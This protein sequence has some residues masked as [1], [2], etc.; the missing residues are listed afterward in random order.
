[1]CPSSVQAEHHSRMAM[2]SSHCLSAE[3]PL[4]LV[5]GNFDFNNKSPADIPWIELFE[6]RIEM[7]ISLAWT[8]KLT[9]RQSM[10]QC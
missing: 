7:A 10:V 3:K 8:S 9:L 4:R 1:M 6:S 2:R 5:R